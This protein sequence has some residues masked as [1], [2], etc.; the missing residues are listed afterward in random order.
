MADAAAHAAAMADAKQKLTHAYTVTDIHLRVKVLDGVKLTYSTWVKLFTLHVKAYKLADHI[1]GTAPP[2]ATDPLYPIWCDIDSIVLQWLYGTLS[3][4]LLIRI[5]D[6]NTTARAAWL[7]LHGIFQNNKGARAAALDQ[8]VSTL[9]LNNCS[10]LDVYCQN[11]QDLAEQLSN[12]GRPV[13]DNRKVLQLVRGLPPEYDT[14][15]S[16]INLNTPTWDEARNM[17]HLELQRIN[18]RQNPNPTSHVLAATTNNPNPPPD[19]PN[20]TPNTT[21]TEPHQ[22]TPYPHNQPPTTTHQPYNRSQPT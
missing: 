19:I 11:I 6:T 2:D 5:V 13:D 20:P 15:A 4:D 7:K 22:L 14:V 1:D 10:S 9:T 12:V 16:Y 17:L 21:Q 3:D 8:E 18:A